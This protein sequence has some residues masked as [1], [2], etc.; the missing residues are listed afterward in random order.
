MRDHAAFF[1]YA[2]NSV[3]KPKVKVIPCAHLHLQC[4]LPVCAFSLLDDSPAQIGGGGA[5][6]SGKWPGKNK[7]PTGGW[8]VG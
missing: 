3:P 5:E 6:K 2:V 4:Q 8:E 1:C 7:W